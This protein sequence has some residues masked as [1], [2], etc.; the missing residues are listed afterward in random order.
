[1][2]VLSK[3][4]YEERVKPEGLAYRDSDYTAMIADLNIK[5]WVMKLTLVVEI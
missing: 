2:R 3:L 5:S 4:L 1:M